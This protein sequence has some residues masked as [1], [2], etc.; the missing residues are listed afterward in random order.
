MYQPAQKEVEIRNYWHSAFSVDRWFIGRLNQFICAGS[1]KKKFSLK[2][3]CEII[4]INSHFIWSKNS[5]FQENI[6]LTIQAE[7][8]KKFALHN[9]KKCLVFQFPFIFLFFILFFISEAV[10]PFKLFNPIE[11]PY[12]AMAFPMGGLPLLNCY[13]CKILS[14]CLNYNQKMW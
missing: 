2:S 1:R 9:G 13:N 7:L 14:P 5:Y 11:S 4:S 6:V 8:I 12:W 3:R 10:F